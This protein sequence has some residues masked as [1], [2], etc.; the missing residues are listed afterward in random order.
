M[1]Q[2]E[3]SAADSGEPPAWREL[4]DEGVQKLIAD[5]R[6]LAHLSD[7]VSVF[8]REMR[9][10][11]VSRTID[12]RTRA[13]VLGSCVLQHMPPVDRERFRRAFLESWTSGTPRV[14]EALD[15]RGRWWETRLV[16]VKGDDGVAHMLGASVDISARKQAEQALSERESRLRYAIEASGVGTWSWQVDGDEV[17]WDEGLCRIYGVDPASAPHLYGRYV[18]HIHPDDRAYVEAQIARS[19]QT[20][21]YEDFEHRIVRPSGEV[22]Y[23]FCRGSALCGD[24]GRVVALRGGIF[25]ITERRQLEEQ[26]RHA[27]KMDAIGQLTAGIAH[28]FNNLLSIVLPNVELCRMRAPRE[29]HR[30]L[31]DIEHAAERAADMVRQL[32]RFARHELGA[33]KCAVDLTTLAQRTVSICR[34]T[35]DRRIR[36]EL[37]SEPGL[38]PVLARPGDIAQVLLNICINARDALEEGRVEEPSIVLRL[39]RG[40]A[41]VR[42]QVTDNGPGMPE[43]Q[44]AR[45]FE[46]FF[47]T[48]QIGKGTGL[49][50]AS[51]YGIVVDHRGTIACASAPGVGT[52]FTIE[53]PI[54]EPAPVESRGAE[55]ARGRE[56]ETVLLVDDEPLL[57][58][59]I[60]GVLEH[61]GYR[62][63][64]SEGGPEG[65][66]LL[67]QG[68][69]QVDLVLLDRSMPRMSGEA[70]L[71][72]MEA[73]GVRVPVV[74]LTG[75]P[76]SASEVRGAR[77]VLLKPPGSALLCKTVREVLDAGRADH[78]RESAG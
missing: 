55:P 39:E 71:A 30:H 37:E 56:R 16:P 12:D 47:T 20:G 59:A 75:D 38:P 1:K 44:R 70:F 29:I 5:P 60:R 41:V 2:N 65:L 21:I 77:A 3:E 6:L 57:R 11:Y 78:G 27:Q 54:A 36:I 66:A 64:E 33:H 22:R 35:F 62:V 42:L 23:V 17:V 50:L 68:S 63:R 9:F 31:D 34:S 19:L 13:L 61:A 24:D 67:T 28:N 7:I 76:G 14:V 40:E 49:G 45:L 43:E 73:S 52:S 53:L 15:D 51:A 18:E 10:T 74:L 8:D 26:L 48:K 4:E 58:R 72:G 25:D 69:E 46:P 32:M